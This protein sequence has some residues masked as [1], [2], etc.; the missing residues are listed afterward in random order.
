VQS[1]SPSE[2]RKSDADMK[3]EGKEYKEELRQERL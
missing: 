2:E 1:R 3:D